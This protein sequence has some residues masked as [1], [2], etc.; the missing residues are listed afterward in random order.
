MINHTQGEWA[1]SNPE[2]NGEVDKN[3][4]AISAGKG[5]FTR[6]NKD[7][8][9]ATSGFEARTFLQ[10]GD[11]VLLA[12]AK[13]MYDMLMEITR[14]GTEDELLQA[15]KNADSLL[16]EMEAQANEES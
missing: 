15:L 3:Y 9:D 5:F 4:F 1:L 10:R 6:E 13:K 14:A 12:N 7:Y 8:G 11:A 2:V 16:E